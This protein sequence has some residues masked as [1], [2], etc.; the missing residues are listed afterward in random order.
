MKQKLRNIFNPDRPIEDRIFTIVL[1]LGFLVCLASTVVTAFEDI[2]IYATLFTAFTSVLFIIIAFI[3]FRLKKK[4]AAR[5]LLC[6]LINC[7]L[8]PV[9]F[10]ACGGI[11][12]G[13]PL[14]F[15]AG[16]FIIIPLLKSKARIACL[17][18]TMI[19]ETLAIGVSYNFMDGSKG[20]FLKDKNLLA[21][22]SLESRVIDVLASYVLVAI[23]LGITTLLI[24]HSYQMEKER[25]DKLN[26]TLENYTKTDELTGLAN[27]RELFR[28]LDEKSAELSQDETFFIAMLDIDHFKIINDVYGHMFGD[29]ALRCI[30]SVMKKACDPDS[31]EMAARYGGEEFVIIFKEKSINFAKDRMDKLRRDVKDLKWQEDENLCITISGGLVKCVECDGISQMLSNADKLL[32]EAKNSG[33]N[34]I[35]TKAQSLFY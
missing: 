24:L 23:F 14:Y 34:K 18:S 3:N 21:K 20:D 25:S 26:K 30:A 13:M 2:G 16:I 28:Y 17:V 9:L 32:Y 8:M 29:E 4:N 19:L 6:F 1:L 10:F 22:L 11:D 5:I 31:D 12:S 7:I 33:R 27:R 35:M 15:L